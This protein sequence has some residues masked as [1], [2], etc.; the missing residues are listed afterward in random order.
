MI[1]NPVQRTRRL[2]GWERND[3]SHRLSTKIPIPI[4]YQ[5]VLTLARIDFDMGYIPTLEIKD[6]KGVSYCQGHHIVMSTSDLSFLTFLH[7]LTHARGFGSPQNPHSRGFVLGY[8]DMMVW[9]LGWDS[10]E[11]KL[12]AHSLGLI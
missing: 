12:Q 6:M 8:I 5:W 11:L 4:H 1:T 2:Y 9:G 3:L 7:E 10:D